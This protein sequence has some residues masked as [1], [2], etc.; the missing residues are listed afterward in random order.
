[1]RDEM[2]ELRECAHGNCFGG[3][4]DRERGHRTGALR[5]S[6]ARAR[7][8]SEQ[9]RR[10]NSGPASRSTVADTSQT[11]GNA[12]D[13]WFAGATIAASYR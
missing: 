10:D 6:R 13:Y 3:M 11:N 12:Q 9:L 1:M 5:F 4:R 7:L 8:S 2:G